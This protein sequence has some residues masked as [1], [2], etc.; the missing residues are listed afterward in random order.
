MNRERG[1]VDGPAVPVP[2]WANVATSSRW[3][4]GE[5]G[6]VFR[7]HEADTGRGVTVSQQ[8][9]A[10]PAGVR[11]EAPAVLVSLQGGSEVLGAGE[12]RELAAALVRGAE[13]V[14]AIGAES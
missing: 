10:G 3:E 14:E 2:G 13:L 12:A 8:V 11:V 5:R 4:A 6:E 7:F 1:D 9:T